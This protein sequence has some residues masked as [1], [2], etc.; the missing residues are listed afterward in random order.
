MAL[1]V[2]RWTP[3]DIHTVQH[4]AWTTWNAAYGSFIPES[5]LRAFF[6]EY[7][8]AGQLEPYCTDESA[9]GLLAELDEE[10]AGFARTMLKR[11]EGRFYLTSLYVLPEFQGHGIGS[12]LLHAAE[13]F[14]ATLGA[15]ELWLG[16]MT[17]NTAALDW[18]RRIG[19]RFDREERFTMGQTTV[20]LLIGSRALDPTSIPPT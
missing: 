5:D 10:P 13:A 20:P 16:V 3:M 12:R 6:D 2:R 17:Q 11:D 4:I 7:F 14:G 15:R 19:F 18:Y 9:A 1:V 8:T